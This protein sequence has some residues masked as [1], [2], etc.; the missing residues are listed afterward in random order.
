LLYHIR[1]LKA[2]ANSCLWVPP[3]PHSCGSQDKSSSFEPVLS[4]WPARFGLLGGMG[5]CRVCR[6]T[7]EFWFHGPSHNF[8]HPPNTPT[9][10][11][12][13]RGTYFYTRPWLWPFANRLIKSRM[14]LQTTQKQEALVQFRLP[15]R[16][17]QSLGDT[18]HD[19]DSFQP[20]YG[21]SESALAG[22][23]S[24]RVVGFQ[25]RV[26]REPNF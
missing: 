4:T 6:N 15:V 16:H 22:P 23:W 10:S 8:L 19:C 2:F 20:S 14:C 13:P 5:L 21:C 26:W 9:F 24:S 17:P 1:R 18:G 12:L 11:Q 25:T 3:P 7:S